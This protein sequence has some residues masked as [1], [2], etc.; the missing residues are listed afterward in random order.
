MA[1]KETKIETKADIWTKSDFDQMSMLFRWVGP[2]YE[3]QQNLIWHFLKKY[4][5]PNYPKP[6]ASCNCPM[7]YANAFNKLRD[8]AFANSEKFIN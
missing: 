6:I 2:F 8:F 7:S 1:K 3:E 5:D 4:V